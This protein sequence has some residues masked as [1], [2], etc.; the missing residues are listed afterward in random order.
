MSGALKRLTTAEGEAVP[1]GEKGFAYQY[2]LKDHPGNV[3]AV[4]RDDDTGSPEV[5]Q[6]KTYY[7]FGM[8]FTSEMMQGTFADKTNSYLFNGKEQQE[9]PGLWYDYGWRFY[10]PQIGRFLGVDPL[11]DK[12]I[13]VSPYNFAENSPIANVDY[14]GLQAVNYQAAMAISNPKV[15]SKMVDQRNKAM[16]NVDMK[17]SV[18]AGIQAG[19]T[20]N[21]KGAYLNMASVD[22]V[23]GSKKSGFDYAG[24]DGTTHVTQGA[25]LFVFSFDHS[26][27]AKPI[28]SENEETSFTVL[29]AKL[30]LVDNDEKTDDA[31]ANSNNNSVKESS[32]SEEK[33]SNSVVEIK[34]DFVINAA[35][36]LGVEFEI[37]IDDQK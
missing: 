4:I 27:D 19:G 22:L 35:F 10:D 14:W 2:F 23:S 32:N 16:E 7:P 12:F 13:W 37:T 21:K 20:F 11:A 29:N 31:D 26:F 15:Y 17:L 9:M 1:M 34:P 8:V 33:S 5:I 25:S 24:K 28:G 18:S 36:F 6:A 3:R 30:S